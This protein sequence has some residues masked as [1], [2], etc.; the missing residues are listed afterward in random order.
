[1]YDLVFVT[2]MPSFYKVNLYNEINKKCKVFV[3][4]LGDQSIERTS[5]FVGSQCEF[6]YVV[7]NKGNFEERSTALSLMKLLLVIARIKYKK[8]VLSGWNLLEFWLLLFTSKSIKNVLCL[9]S[10]IN[11]SRVD[12]KKGLLK[13]LF[14]KRVGTVLASGSLHVQLLEQMDYEGRILVTRGVGIINKPTFTA[15]THIYQKR[16]LFLGR[17]APEK[18]LDL[19]ITVFNK[20]QDYSLTIVGNGPLKESLSSRTGKNITFLD[21]V[22]NDEIGKLFMGHN[23]LILGSFSEPW[24]LVVEEALY[25]GIP[26]LVSSTCGSSE[27]I[28]EGMN[29]YKFSPHSEK[30]LIEAVLRFNDDD[31]QKM[32]KNISKYSLDLK[33]KTQVQAYLECLK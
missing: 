15:T 9:E 33:D 13:K 18:N 7:L 25:Y 24:G 14:L 19:L 11:E 8:I 28:E 23:V 32:I 31:Y 16:F 4:F 10:T 26:A 17:L 1:M 21:H 2:Q 29:G 5:D 27:L 3:V 6:E 12:G 30:E 22:A 20:L